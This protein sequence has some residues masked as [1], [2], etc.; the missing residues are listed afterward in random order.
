MYMNR[1]ERSVNCDRILQV[2]PINLQQKFGAENEREEQ[3]VLFKERSTHVAV[4]TER[5]MIRQIADS[6]LED[7]G[8]VAGIQIKYQ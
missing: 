3:F 8:L 5:K 2:D 6:T 4:Q 1:G 7:L